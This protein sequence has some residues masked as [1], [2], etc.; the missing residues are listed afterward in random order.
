MQVRVQEISQGRAHYYLIIAGQRGEG[1]LNFWSLYV[2]VKTKIGGRGWVGSG[3]GTP[4]PMAA[5]ALGAF[6]RQLL[7]IVETADSC[8][9]DVLRYVNHGVHCR[10]DGKL[11]TV[12][13]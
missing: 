6:K 4:L 3:H 9:C 13:H 7:V 8:V 11:V 12:H 1:Q 2:K 5:C 10:H